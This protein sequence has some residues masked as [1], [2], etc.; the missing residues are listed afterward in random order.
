MPVSRNMTAERRIR[1]RRSQDRLRQDQVQ[2]Y[3]M[4][5]ELGQL[6]T[7]EINLDALF[8]LIVE[9]TNQ[10]MQTERC[11]VFLH[12]SHK[13]QLW[14]L[15]STDL[16]KD[17]IRFT[18]SHGVAGWVFRHKSALMINDPYNDPRFF[19]D[20]DKKTGFRTRNI[21]CIPLVNRRQ[22]CIG[23]LQT[24]NVKKDGGFT[25]LD[26]ELLASAAVYVTIALENA[27]LY[28]DLKT[29][30]KAKERAINHLSHELRTPLAILSGVLYRIRS[31][32][33][34]GRFAKLG[35]TL[36][37]GERNVE[38]LRDLQTKIDDILN[39]EFTGDK[40]QITRLIED[41]VCFLEE[42]SEADGRQ[43]ESILQGICRRLESVYKHEP[44]SMETIALDIF[45][46]DI[47]E[48]AARSMGQRHLEIVKSFEKK[49]VLVMDRRVLHKVCAGLLKN[50][51]ENTP[52]GGTV[53]I[54]TRTGAH[55]E[56]CI[57]FQDYGVGITAQ[58][59]QLIFDG[60]FHTQD[61]MLY[62]SKKPYA[63]NAGGA[64]ADLLRTRV[65]SERYGFSV[66]FDSSR[67]RFLPADSDVCPGE[68]SA[69]PFIREKEACRASGGSL[70]SIR[71]P[72][73]E[74]A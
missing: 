24:L 30:D 49:R 48:D 7:S 62:S 37:R 64:G 42:A 40:H 2:Q 44:V 70:F 5:F 43:R 32:L 31:S 45:L 10:F 68:I 38:R 18:V 3:K 22:Q 34:G 51:I 50:A 55:R 13:R 21:L 56:V 26:R 25:E 28:E 53:E 69:C 23:T 11:S 59:Q 35:K 46:A 19:P 39:Q 74:S 1:M 9:Q 58:N 12:D 66:N 47:C 57:E 20:V 14:S 16:G 61:T 8:E 60:F 4:L 71:F 72:R 36:A 63:F 6:I 27:T 33:E 41:A 52:D 67:C 65:F 15:V 29:L 54:R 73:I 17:E